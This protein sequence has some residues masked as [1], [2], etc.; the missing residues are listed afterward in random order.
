MVSE[1]LETTGEELGEVKDLVRDLEKEARLGK[2]GWQ[3]RALF[4]MSVSL[5]LRV[6]QFRYEGHFLNVS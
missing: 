4:S 6:Q 2:A 3:E 1:A 5:C